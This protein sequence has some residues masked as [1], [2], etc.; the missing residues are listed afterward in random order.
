MI[1]SNLKISFFVLITSTLL[2]YSLSSA[3]AQEDTFSN[4][5]GTFIQT[6]KE[7]LRQAF[8]IWQNIHQK[9]L[10]Y[11]KGYLLP[12]IQNLI[13]R[14]ISKREPIIRQQIQEE[15]TQIKE[16]IKEVYSKSWQWLKDIF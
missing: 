9:I 3:L 6:L 14:E 13:K 8:Q 4:L 7:S 12:K 11:W 15:K 5:S 16:D 2:F 10:N 1:Y